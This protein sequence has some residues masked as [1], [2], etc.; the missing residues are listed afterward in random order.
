MS[1]D[2]YAPGREGLCGHITGP[3]APGSRL[4]PCGWRCALH[5]PLALRGITEDAP[6]SGIPAPAPTSTDRATQA[7]VDH[8]TELNL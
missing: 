8:R 6:G 2:R 5:S 4:Y 7:A 1:D 3:H